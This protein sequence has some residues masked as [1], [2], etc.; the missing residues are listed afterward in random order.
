MRGLAMEEYRVIMMIVDA[1]ALLRLPM[2]PALFSRLE[3]NRIF[4]HQ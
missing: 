4:G 2:D 1:G 3:G